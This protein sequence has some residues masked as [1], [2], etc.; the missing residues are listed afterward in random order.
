MLSSSPSSP[1]TS[2]TLPSSTRTR[3]R[4]LS[5]PFCT[6]PKTGGSGPSS[7]IR[8]VGRCEVGGGRARLFVLHWGQ[9]DPGFQGRSRGRLSHDTGGVDVAQG[10]G[11]GVGWAR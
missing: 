4:R 10:E 2:P 7:T 9:A 1:R 5:S 6:P 11:L 3:R 8:G